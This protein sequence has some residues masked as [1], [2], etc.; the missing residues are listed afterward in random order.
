MFFP[1]KVLCRLQLKY[2]RTFYPLKWSYH[3]D[4]A[5]TWKLQAFELFRPHELVQGTDCGV[6]TSIEHNL[7]IFKRLLGVCSA[8]AVR[9]E[10]NIHNL[11]TSTNQAGKKRCKNAGSPCFPLF[12]C[13]FH[14]NCVYER[15]QG[16]ETGLRTA[17]HAL[18]A[19]KCRVLVKWTMVWGEQLMLDFVMNPGCRVQISMETSEFG[20]F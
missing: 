2:L 8:L 3:W 10:L 20:I 16:N 15:E 6:H 5:E 11:P 17:L 13:V 1:H 19:L 18:C 14:F 4:T 12:F 7:F 9:C